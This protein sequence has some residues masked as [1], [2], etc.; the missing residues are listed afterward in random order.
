MKS[1]ERIF[2]EGQLRGRLVD[3]RASDA[4]LGAVLESQRLPVLAL[5]LGALALPL[6]H[7]EDEIPI[8]EPG[9]DV[10][11]PDDVSRTGVRL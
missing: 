1:P 10:S 7:L 11:F 4:D 5:E 3:L 6:A 8:V 2:C 9:Q